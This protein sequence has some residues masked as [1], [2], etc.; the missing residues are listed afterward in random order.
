M[1]KDEGS[2]VYTAAVF[3][4]DATSIL[5]NFNRANGAIGSNWK[6]STSAYRIASNRVDVRGNGPIYWKNS[7][8]VNQEA[9]VTLTTVDMAGKE[10]DLLLKV[11]GGVVPNWGAGVIEVS[12]H[13]PTNS[14]I[15]YT[16]RPSTLQWHSY[17]AIPVS[18]SNGDQL[19][20]QALANGDVVIFKNGV[21][22][23]R[24]TLNSADQAFFN[25]RGGYIGLWFINAN[26]AFFDDFGGG[27][28]I[29]P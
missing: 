3:V 29:L 13:A 5:D 7:F 12:Y 4:K 23:G 2:N 14:V 21:E 17:S 11:Q 24:V 20:A 10:Q 16:F 19:G 1:D 9:S 26:N 25:P 8:G 15:V 6:G 28:I 22:V 18:F 27:N